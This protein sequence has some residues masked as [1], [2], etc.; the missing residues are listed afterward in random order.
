MKY[1]LI[2]GFSMLTILSHS[3]ASFFG[4]VKIEYEKTVAVKALYK[5]IASDWYDNIKD[6]LPQSVNSYFEFIGDTVHSLYHQTKEAPY[7]PRDFFQPFADKN[8]VFNNYK[9]GQ[10]ISQKPIF[11]KTFLLE[12]SLLNIR[13][14]I[15]NDTRRIA[16]FECRKAVGILF[17]TVAVFAFYTDELTISGGPEGIHGLPGMILGMGIPR[18]HTTWFATKVQVV[19]VNTKTLAPA[20]KGEKV[21]RKTMFEAMDK[22]LSDWEYGKK[23][24]LAT[25]I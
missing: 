12:D 15:T 21:N 24:I 25:L 18:L 4:T 11:E 14:K 5:E 22:V 10:T 3:Q 20:A 2:A 23:M 13:W 16:G 17:D 19:D 6:R 7:D 8:V 1:I 9:T